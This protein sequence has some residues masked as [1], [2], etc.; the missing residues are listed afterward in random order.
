MK[1][2]IISFAI[3]VALSF[4]SNFCF[5][6]QEEQK[7]NAPKWVSDKGYWVVESNVHTPKSNTLYF[8]NNDHLLV[9]KEKVEGM[10]IKL[11]KKKVLMRLKSVLDQSV[12]A[13]EEQHIAKENAMLVS[14][15]LRK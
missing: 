13:W 14:V 4:F 7:S 9:Y 10:K 11:N 12:T 5:A 15:A 2:T 8:Y 6:Q 1:K 3:A